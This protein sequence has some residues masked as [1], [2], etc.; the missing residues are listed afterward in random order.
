MTARKETHRTLLGGVAS[1]LGKLSRRNRRILGT[2]K[3]EHFDTQGRTV[4]ILVR[5]AHL[6]I[7]PQ[8]GQQ[9]LQQFRFIADGRR[10]A[11]EPARNF[12]HQLVVWQ[13][14]EGRIAQ[15]LVGRRAGG[16]NEP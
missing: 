6:H 10:D 12:G 16:N 1:P 11:V 13:L 14:M 4:L 7:G 15:R 2:A 9:Q 3:R 8:H 5:F